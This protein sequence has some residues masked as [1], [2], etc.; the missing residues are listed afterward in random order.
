MKS[1]PASAALMRQRPPLACWLVIH[2][3]ETV[4]TRNE[5]LQMFGSLGGRLRRLESDLTGGG[6]TW[7][8][9]VAYRGSRDLSRVVRSLE[10]LPGVAVAACREIRSARRPRSPRGHARPGRPLIKA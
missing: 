10:R 9:E 6:L 4:C 5:L 8:L 7:H 1:V 2:F 3:G